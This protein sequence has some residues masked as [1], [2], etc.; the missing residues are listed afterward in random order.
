[1]RR[2]QRKHVHFVLQIFAPKLF[3]FVRLTRLKCP[4]VLSPFTL[5]DVC[6]LDIIY[7]VQHVNGK[8]FPARTLNT[9]FIYCLAALVGL[10]YS[11]FPLL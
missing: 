2:T 11:F 7:N 1:M 4:A 9:S 5:A 6:S 10:C 8:Y 3:H